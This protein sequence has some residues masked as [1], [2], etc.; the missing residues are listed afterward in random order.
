MDIARRTVL[1]VAATPA[2]PRAP[3]RPRPHFHLQVGG[4]AACPPRV[5]RLEWAVK[6][7][8]FAKA[9]R[10]A[11]ICADLYSALAVGDLGA[12][13]D[14]IVAARDAGVDLAQFEGDV[15]LARLMGGGCLG[16]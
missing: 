9:A 1:F 5:E 12:A 16:A 7:T 13:S 15:R 10:E 3:Q 11:A 6:S 14:A 8:G 4:L 2:A